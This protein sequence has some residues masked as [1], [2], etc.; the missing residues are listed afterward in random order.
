MGSKG[1]IKESSTNYVK[2]I[3]PRERMGKITMD[4]SDC[5]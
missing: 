5:S 4:A 1:E 3:C 2:K